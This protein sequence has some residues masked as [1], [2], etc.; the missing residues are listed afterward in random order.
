MSGCQSMGVRIRRRTKVLED[1]ITYRKEQLPN[2]VPASGRFNRIS[3]QVAALE[4]AMEAVKEKYA[5]YFKEETKAP[6]TLNTM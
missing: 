6:C 2:T 4:M 5:P 1:M 3:A